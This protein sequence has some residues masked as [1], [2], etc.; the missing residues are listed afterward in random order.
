MAI[1]GG[2]KNGKA[3]NAK[4]ADECLLEEDDLD[5]VSGGG[6]FYRYD[7]NNRPK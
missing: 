7:P 2:K 4:K 5:Q 1:F 6:G 3:E